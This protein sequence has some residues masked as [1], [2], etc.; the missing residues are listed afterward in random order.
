MR[1]VSMKTRRSGP[2]AFGLTSTPLSARHTPARRRRGPRLASVS[3]STL[4]G[5][6]KM[7]GFDAGII[8]VLD[9]NGN[10]RLWLR[11]PGELF[12]HPLVDRPFERNDQRR[13][14][15]HRL[16]SPVHE[17]RLVAAG[18]MPDV[19]LRILA[20]ETQ[21]VPL[22]RLPAELALPG[23]P[24]NFARDVVAQPLRHFAEL[25][26]RSD[27]G[28]LVELAQRRLVGVLAL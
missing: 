28:L 16:P 23:F 20:G 27:A 4:S 12:D 10:G 9:C 11:K 14:L 13:Q 17:L 5:S 15:V 19:D 21:R 1:T 7:S 6:V 22:L 3:G 25:L 2:S 24:D 18:R 26:D 8:G